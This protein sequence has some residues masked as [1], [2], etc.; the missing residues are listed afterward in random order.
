MKHSVLI[1]II[2]KFD[3]TAFKTKLSSIG[4]PFKSF[5]ECVQTAAVPTAKKTMKRIDSNEAY[6]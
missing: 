3:V 6:R 2:V 4:L 5:F 1:V